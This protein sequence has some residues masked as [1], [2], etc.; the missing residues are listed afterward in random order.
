MCFVDCRKRK[1]R[2]GDDGGDI[3]FQKAQGDKTDG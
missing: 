1:S 3:I 2:E